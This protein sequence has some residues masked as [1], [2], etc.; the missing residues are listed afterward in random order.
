ML[1]RLFVIFGGLLVLALCAALVGPYFVDWSGYK[2][3]FEREA[4]AIL[5]RKVVVQGEV[6]ARILPFPSV[7]FSDVTVGGGAGGN[8]AMTVETFSMDAELAPLLSGEF[9]IYDMRLVRPKAII[10]VAADGVVDWAIRPS[11]PFDAKQISIEKLTITEGQVR[12]RRAASGRDHLLSEINTS[13]SAKSLAG[14]WRV[15]GSLRIDGLK[16]QLSVATGSVDPAGQMRLRVRATPDRYGVVIEGDGNA[17]MDKGRALYS[18]GFSVIEAQAEPVATADGDN[19][20]APAKP[21]EPGFRV[22]GKFALDHA[23]LGVEEFRFESGPLE[24][25]YTAEGTAEVNLGA[26]PHFAVTA[27]GAQ[28]RFDEAVGGDQAGIGFSV[29]ERLTALEKVLV[30]LPRPTIPGTVDV[31]LPAVVAGD[32]TVRDVKMSAEPG[33]GGWKLKSLAATLPGRTRL[34]ADGFLRTEGTLGFDGQMLLA[35]GQ[36]SGFAAWV[37]K[38]VDEAVRKLPAAGFKAKVALTREQQTFDDV[39]L[40]LGK[41]RFTGGLDSM[42]PDDARSSMTMKLDGGELDLDGLRAFASLFV[43]DQGANRF[44]DADLDLAVKA[45]PVNFAG[46]SAE[47]VD[48]ALRLRDGVLEIDKLSV[49][50]L[51]GASL[52]AIGRIKDFPKAPTGNLDASVVAVDLAPLVAL[53]AKQAPENKLLGGLAARAAAYP[54]L[55]AD[56]RIDFVASAVDNG[57][58]TTGIALSG[59]GEAGGS[60]LLATL[61]AQ[62][63]PSALASSQMKLEFSARNEDATS[64]LALAG[65][66][67]LPLGMT[68]P[69]ELALTAKGAVQNGLDVTASLK[70][71]DASA[72]FTGMAAV[73]DGIAN[74]KGRATLQ[75]TDLEPWLMTSGVTLPGMGTGTQVELAADASLG[76]GILMLDRLDGTVNQGAVVGNLKAELNEG[77]PHLSGSLTLD[78]LDLR[79]FAEMTLGAAALESENGAWPTSAFAPKPV[80]PFSADLE[81]I[82]G[83]LLAEPLATA[84][85]AVLAL[86]VDSQALR[87]SNIRAKLFG[88]DLGG[89]IELKNNDGT[90]FISGQLKLDGADVAAIPAGGE[91]GGKGNFSATLSGSGKSVEGLVAS[92]SGSGTADIDGLVLSGFNPDAFAPLIAKADALGRDI[93]AARVAEFAPALAGEGSF[94]A[95]KA[96]IAFTLAGGILRA[97]PL[98]LKNPAAMLNADLRADLNDGVVSAHGSITYAPGKEELV[99][100]EPA[101][102][103][104]IDGE[105]GATVKLFDSAP[106]AQFLTQRALEKE[107]ARVEAMQAVL[108]EK[109]RLRREARYF[110]AVQAER[111]RIAEEARIRAEEEAKAKAEAERLKAEEERRAAEAAAKAQAD[112]ARELALREAEKARQAEEKARLEAE[113]NA[114]LDA[115][116]ARLAAAEKARREAEAAKPAPVSE[117]ERAPLPD[118]RP[119]A[120]PGQASP[121]DPDPVTPETPVKKKIEPLSLD[122]FFKSLQSQ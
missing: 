1:A 12:L 50:G 53:A 36:P 18:G 91:I 97:P 46:L 100:S 11:A 119:M 57:D 81:I 56:A 39:E 99:G 25:P 32:T 26:D 84:H 90:A 48:T 15:D 9:L 54:G 16:T 105:P 107:Q 109:Q 5:G 88:G 102:N 27:N 22:K 51:A 13:I 35:V 49:G 87:L 113:Q 98:T 82:T 112:A 55:L 45:G 73:R 34:E 96:D 110:A 94:T 120:V 59:Q 108:L 3:E 72:G 66:P 37:A 111:E 63:M 33:E 52:S 19:T 101:M 64:L 21:V 122:D 23:R 89:L 106:M 69:G 60:D 71:D 75:A 17:S 77:M 43:T 114:T 40:I 6:V 47:T 74:L 65:L 31:D 42:L 104:Q 62:V 28:V 70:G 80:A 83:T 115:E 67:V 61:S 58:K 86:Q 14:P 7:T 29:S 10:D 92:L 2:A 41:A 30:D 68:G 117:I 20:K 118:A 95:G 44:S 121:A 85:D 116:K 4:S 24:D 79:P 103:F 78:E 76:G 8:D 38:D 93:N